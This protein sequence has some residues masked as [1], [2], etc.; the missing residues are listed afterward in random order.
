[1]NDINLLKKKIIYR[2]EHR[3]IKEMDILLSNFVKKYINKFDIIELK[4]LKDLLN[5]DDNNLFKWYLNKKSKIQIPK[6]KI[7][8]LLKRFKI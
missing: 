4:Q 3:G 8:N 2:S 1:M 6:N 5:I 7:S